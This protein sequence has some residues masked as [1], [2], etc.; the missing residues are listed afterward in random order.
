MFLLRLGSNL[1]H[2]VL[3]LIFSEPSVEPSVSPRR[4]DTV[5]PVGVGGIGRNPTNH[6]CLL[7]FP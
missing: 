6:A 2:D 5:F 7:Y 3:A 4:I 1:S